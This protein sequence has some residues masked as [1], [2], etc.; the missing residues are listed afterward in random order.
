[1]LGSC[2]G[3]IV[4][5]KRSSPDL[6]DIWKLINNGTPV[7]L[8]LKSQKCRRIEVQPCSSDEGEVNIKK[9]K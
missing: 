3:L 7:T 9:K 2:K 8:W 5:A 1:M 4:L 6:L